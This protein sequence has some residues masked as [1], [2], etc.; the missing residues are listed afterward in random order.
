[1]TR[2]LSFFRLLWLAYGIILLSVYACDSLAGPEICSSV[3]LVPST[4]PDT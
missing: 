1:M 4:G 3:L 2:H